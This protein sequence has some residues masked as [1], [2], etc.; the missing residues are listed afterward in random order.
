MNLNLK[1]RYFLKILILK[2]NIS[3]LVNNAFNLIFLPIQ[4]FNM[5]CVFNKI[6]NKQILFSYFLILIQSDNPKLI[7]SVTPLIDPI[8]FKIK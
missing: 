7:Q 3:L 2:L 8:I 6:D 5:L 4:D 1:W